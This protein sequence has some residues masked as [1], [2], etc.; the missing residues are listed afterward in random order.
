VAS[1][2]RDGSDVVRTL[3]Q[4]VGLAA[5]LVALLYAAG[6]G[7]LALRLYLAHL[8]S[9]TIAAQLPRDLLISVGLG[10]IVLPIL[11]VAGLYATWRMLRGSVAPPTRLVR[12]WKERSPRDWSELVAG[13][14]LPALV[15]AGV[16]G[17]AKHDVRGGWKG[18]AWLLPLTFV[19]T[20]LVFLVGLN[21]RAR[22]VDSYGESAS[23]WSA[24]RPVVRMTL[25]VA[26]VFLP[27]CVLFAGVFY[28]LLDAKVCMT[29]GSDA[30]G[31]LIG[32][33]SD[34]TYIGQKR[35]AAGP[36]LVFSV[37][38]SEIR[39]TFIGRNAGARPCPVAESRSG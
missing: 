11:A 3:G 25:V 33:T 21:L 10:Q 4:L 19:L 9:R 1:A 7:V 32:E 22:L 2:D 16:L 5:G 31:V 36:L 26:L 35:N 18:L 28:T 34:R 38:R 8:P 24:V 30:K 17:L 6:G 39:Q 27:I 20:V 37:P 12:Q 13:S 15:V 23:S 29:S 14:A